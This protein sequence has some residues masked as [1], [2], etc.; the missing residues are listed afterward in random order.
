MA[1]IAL[2]DVSHR[3]CMRKRIRLPRPSL[4]QV[5]PAA[6]P[7][8]LAL[9]EQAEQTFLYQLVYDKA[10]KT[11][12]PLHP[13]PEGLD[14]TG[15]EHAGTARDNATAAAVAEG[16][17]HP[18]TLQA[19]P[20]PPADGREED[21]AG[22]GLEVD[23]IVIVRV[24][25]ERYFSNAPLDQELP[26][27]HTFTN[28]DRASWNH[29]DNAARNQPFNGRQTKGGTMDRDGDGNF[30]G[31]EDCRRGY[32]A[33][34]IVIRTPAGQVVPGAIRKGTNGEA[35]C[36]DALPW[37]GRQAPAHSSPSQPQLTSPP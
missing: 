26:A 9:F 25:V 3:L 17:I 24:N 6:P 5:V 22:D 35:L 27:D 10:T 19:F 16:H 15:L 20:S 34:A 18:V 8:Y 36:L 13:Y 12:V 4:P 29:P 31:K 28:K 11:T 21:N 23:D 7:G 2:Q 14:P 32:G 30:A 33:G 37:R 1:F